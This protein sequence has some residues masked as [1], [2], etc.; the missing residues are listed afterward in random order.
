MRKGT[1]WFN[2][3]KSVFAA[4]FGVQSRANRERDFAEGKAWHFIVGGIVA[5]LLFIGLMLFW[6]QS[7]LPA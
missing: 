3:L 5:T 6:V 2:V 4:F 1:G 7:M